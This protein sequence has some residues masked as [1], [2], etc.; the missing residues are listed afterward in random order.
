MNPT[1]LEGI[2]FPPGTVLS[3]PAYS[4]HH[5]KEVWGPD[6]DEFVPDRW[7]EES[8]KGGR[9]TERMK[10]SFIPFSYGPRACVGRN[11]AEVS[12]TFRY[13]VSSCFPL[14]LFFSSLR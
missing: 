10:A 9:L 6:A 14:D 13:P 12:L 1:T 11:V 7:I 5:S 2:T 4:L 8:E 3:V